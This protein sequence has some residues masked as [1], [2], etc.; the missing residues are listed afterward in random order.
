MSAPVVTP[1]SDPPAAPAIEPPKAATSPAPPVVPPS[2]PV[3]TD[4]KA[5]SRKWEQ[6]AKDNSDAAAR[7]KEIEDAQKSTE[8]KTAE[9]RAA[10]DKRA[11][12]AEARLLRYEVAAAKKIPADALDFLSG[13]TREQIEASA[14]KVLKLIASSTPAPPSVGAHVPGEGI[15][16]AGASQ[17]SKSDLDRMTAARDYEGISKAKAEGRFNDLLGLK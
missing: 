16:S 3:E 5:E 13:D 6:R 14:D 17:L 1:P 4:W 7:L 2:A 15:G 11:A 9:A 12:D 8:Q 10:S